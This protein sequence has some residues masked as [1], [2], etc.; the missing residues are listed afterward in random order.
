MSLNVEEKKELSD[1]LTSIKLDEVTRFPISNMS[2]VPL[3]YMK[4]EVVFKSKETIY[5]FTLVEA[6]KKSKHS[7]T[8][9]VLDKNGMH[10][11]YTQNA[12]KEMLWIPD[13][14]ETI[15]DIKGTVLVIQEF[16]ND[17]ACISKFL[18]AEDVNSESIK[19]YLDQNLV[20][21]QNA[22]F[23]IQ[24]ENLDA[25]ANL[26]NKLWQEDRLKPANGLSTL[27]NITTS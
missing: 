1:L 4:H 2:T 27:Q 18:K 23:Y 9:T 26:C 13:I 20:I 6:I 10:F 21:F 12:D 11:Y 17:G 8:V 25:L 7:A 24:R 5:A 16:P 14:R 22:N 15:K 19:P 3:D